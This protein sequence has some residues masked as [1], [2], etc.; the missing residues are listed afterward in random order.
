MFNIVE[1][2]QHYDRKTLQSPPSLSCRPTR[3]STQP[4][5]HDP[6]YP[7][8]TPCSGTTTTTAACTS[9]WTG[10]TA[11]ASSAVTRS[12]KKAAGDEDESTSTSASWILTP[13]FSFPRPSCSLISSTGSATSTSSP[14][15]LLCDRWKQLLPFC[16][17]ASD[18]RWKRKRI[19]SVGLF[20][21]EPH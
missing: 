14:L 18:L 3:R 19:G 21:E 10:K 1:V 16:T 20:W 13:G 5:V 17:A 11:R 9:A 12:V 6:W 7:W 15:G 2:G 8:A 4:A